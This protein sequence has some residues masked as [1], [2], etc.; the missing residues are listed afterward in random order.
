MILYKCIS[1][2]RFQKGLTSFS[3]RTNLYPWIFSR[4][5]QATYRQPTDQ[6]TNTRTLRHL[7]L[8]HLTSSHLTSLDPINTM[9][10]QERRD[11]QASNR[12]YVRASP[13]SLPRLLTHN[14]PPYQPRRIPE[15]KFQMLPV[16]GGGGGGNVDNKP[17]PLFHGSGG[18]VDVDLRENSWRRD[19]ENAPVDTNAKM[20][21]TKAQEAAKRAEISSELPNNNSSYCNGLLTKVRGLFSNIRDHLPLIA[22]IVH[23]CS[24]AA[25]F[26]ATYAYYATNGPQ[27]DTEHH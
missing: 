25:A 23:I 26:I 15:P 3:A 10:T 7:T 19:L 4:I 18:F 11:H 12:E 8:T 20:M 22:P 9:T 13:T 6:P 27:V 5:L 14:I 17:A 21:K 16:C 1:I 2:S 24:A